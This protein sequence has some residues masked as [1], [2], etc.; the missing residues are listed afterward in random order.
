MMNK[1]SLFS[2]SE[3]ENPET[4]WRTL[5]SAVVF[6]VCS[7]WEDAFHR[8]VKRK[9][10]FQKD[11]DEIWECEDWL[12]G[13]LPLFFGNVDGEALLRDLKKKVNFEEVMRCL[14]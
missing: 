10:T 1:Q 6:Q 11:L 7:D 13:P 8:A 5:G 9:D 3:W 4:C 12:L 14:V 2:E